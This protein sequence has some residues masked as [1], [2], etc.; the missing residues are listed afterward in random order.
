MLFFL[1][2]DIQ[3][4]KTRWLQALC[5]KLE[6]RNVVLCGV[7]APGIWVEHANDDC[8]IAYEKTGILNELLP[9]HEQ[10]VFAKRADLARAE[11]ALDPRSQSERSK[12]GWAI[13]DRAI[14]RVNDH[15]ARIGAQPPFEGKGN[16]RKPCFLVI[17]EF[18]RLELAAGEGLTAGVKLIDDGASE[19][20][21]HALVVVR[22]QL[23]QT[24]LDRFAH[25]QWNG[26]TPIKPDEEGKQAILSA[27]ASAPAS[28]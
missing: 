16:P 17:D 20:I 19:A 8:S 23:L 5:S 11:H 2:G 3:T 26:M 4:G 18:G 1:T 22:E 21:P 28:I 7:I 15:L 6:N 10:I 24:A 25:A 12:L 13:D 27:F 14:S 9:S